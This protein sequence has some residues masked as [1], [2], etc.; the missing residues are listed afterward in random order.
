MIVL[1][2]A[3]K[4]GHQNKWTQPVHKHKH[5]RRDSDKVTMESPIRTLSAVT[6]DNKQQDWKGEKGAQNTIRRLLSQP[7]ELNPNNV[8]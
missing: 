7:I 4:H 3:Y 2:L 6:T 1:P 5:K 8:K